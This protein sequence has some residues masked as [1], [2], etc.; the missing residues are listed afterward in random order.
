MI[1][2]AR[3]YQRAGFPV[4]FGAGFQQGFGG[5]ARFG[6]GGPGYTIDSGSGVPIPATAA[7]WSAFNAAKSL[8]S[9][10]PT[11]LYN[12]NEGSGNAVDVIAAKNLV[13]NA[14]P[15]YDRSFSGWTKHGIEFNGGTTQRLLLSSFGDMAANSVAILLLAAF[16]GSTPA[17]SSFVLSAG[18]SDDFSVTAGSAGNQPR[19]R[20]REGANI[21]QMA[22]NYLTIVPVF[23]MHDIAGS[24]S[25]LFSPTERLAP[26]YG[27]TTGSNFGLGALS[28]V[29][30]TYLAMYCAVWF[31]A[32]GVWAEAD[33]KSLIQAFTFTVTWTPV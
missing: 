16:T 27:A 13:P 28:G 12:L 5:G 19:W 24:R 14:S 20:W 1:M 21:L 2:R 25:R 10:A 8:S 33:I 29:S 26:T 15:L 23:A 3:P 9:P 11:S 22:S 7:E 4:G 17:A 30:A 32:T 6:G 31:G 18:S